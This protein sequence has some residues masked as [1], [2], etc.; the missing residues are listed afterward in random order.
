MLGG[1]TSLPR[2]IAWQQSIISVFE[3]MTGLG[4][5]WIDNVYSVYKETR[6]YFDKPWNL[7][8]AIALEYPSKEG[9][10]PEK[11]NLDEVAEFLE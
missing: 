4:S 11:K 8:R 5:L 7:S 9:M 6:E 2:N 3:P 10:V 1:K